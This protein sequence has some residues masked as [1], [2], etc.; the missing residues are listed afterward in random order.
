MRITLL[1]ALTTGRTGNLPT[2][3]HAATPAIPETATIGARSPRNKEHQ[4]PGQ[5][6]RPPTMHM[7]NGADDEPIQ[8]RQRTK[9]QPPRR[10]NV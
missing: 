6:T 2:T 7:G 8:T 10:A 5:S 1:V 4:R 9:R 3:N